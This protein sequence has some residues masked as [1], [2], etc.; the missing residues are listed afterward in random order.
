MGLVGPQRMTK[1]LLIDRI[2]KAH[3][4]NIPAISFANVNAT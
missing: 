4:D 1:G 3:Y 2:R